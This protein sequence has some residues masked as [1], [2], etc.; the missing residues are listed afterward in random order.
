MLIYTNDLNT[1]AY[2]VFNSIL[3]RVLIFF[4][5]YIIHIYYIDIYILSLLYSITY[6]LFDN[7]KEIACPMQCSR[8]IFV[9]VCTSSYAKKSLLLLIIM[10]LE[11]IK[12]N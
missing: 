4:I 2:Q 10:I 5:L 12:D 8:N 3:S 7:N 1:H 11:L 6:K 9:Y